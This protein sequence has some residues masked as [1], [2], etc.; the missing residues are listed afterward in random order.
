VKSKMEF[1][2]EAPIWNYQF[3]IGPPVDEECLNDRL[4]K[5]PQKK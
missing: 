2:T 1:Y 3:S 4:K 5:T